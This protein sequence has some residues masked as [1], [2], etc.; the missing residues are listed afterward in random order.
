[1]RAMFVDHI[2]APE[3]T[4]LTFSQFT[5]GSL[6]NASLTDPQLQ[7]SPSTDGNLSFTVSAQGGVAAWAWLE[8]P[9]NTIGVFVDP[10]G[11]PSNAFYVVP[12]IDRQGTVALMKS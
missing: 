4:L 8:H 5:P 1:M 9:A 11:V 7:L 2:L 6:A 12:G 10:N 3:T